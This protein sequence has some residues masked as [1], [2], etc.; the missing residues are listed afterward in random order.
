VTSFSS[1]SEGGLHI[2]QAWPNTRLVIVGYSGAGIGVGKFDVS[3]SDAVPGQ[4]LSNPV[5]MAFGANYAFQRTVVSIDSEGNIGYTPTI[6]YGGIT[7]AMDCS[8][9]MAF[10]TRL[11]TRMPVRQRLLATVPLPPS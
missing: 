3:N 5:T 2:A 4:D 7:V 10:I 11:A 6:A 8:A 1:K 9:A